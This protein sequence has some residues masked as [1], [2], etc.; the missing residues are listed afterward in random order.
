MKQQIENILL[1][2]LHRG[3]SRFDT[4][5]GSVLTEEEWAALIVMATRH[6]VAPLLYQRLKALPATSRLPDATLDHWRGCYLSTAA[7]NMCLY[8][9]LRVLLLA[10]HAA[11]IPVIILKGAYLAANVYRDIALRPMSDIDILTP[12][13]VV[14]D[15]LRVLQ[16]AGYTLCQPSTE[17]AIPYHGKDM[18]LI[19]QGH[20]F[21]V[22]VHWTLTDH[23]IQMNMEEWWAHSQKTCIDGIETNILSPE[24][25]LLHIGL[26]ASYHHSFHVNLKALMDI[27]FFIERFQETLNW[28]RFCQ[29]TTHYGW[30]N[31][32]Y[33]ILSLA[34]NLVGAAVPFER[35]ESIK[36]LDFPET[37]MAIA[38]DRL[39]YGQDGP[40]TLSNSF[41]SLWGEKGLGEKFRTIRR[42]VFLSREAIAYL[43]PVQ[44]DSPW[45]WLYYLIRIKDLVIRY[46]SLW[47]RLLYGDRELMVTV[48]QRD[49]LRE[50]MFKP[51]EGARG[52][53]RNLS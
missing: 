1:A 30:N 8:K 6:G 45:L 26:H 27:A 28:D 44:P 36:P 50:W 32:I 23:G 20:Y 46:G 42:S 12:K 2:G 10:L 21:P 25:F 16:D 49:A 15:A 11:G 24:D 29:C 33:P 53:S 13:I 22:E 41:V 3:A 17:A 35:L 5:N 52:E 18:V 39:L 51:M 48:R 43:Y 19:K 4:L 14:R 40:A 9:E 31:G 34:K 7:S 47:W 37:M 38:E